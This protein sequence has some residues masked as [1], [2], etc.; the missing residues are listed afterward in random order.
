MEHHRRIDIAA[1]GPHYQSFQGRHA[2]GGIDRVAVPDRAR[3]GPRA[4]MEGHE[5]GSGLVQQPGD[6]LSQVPV[7]DPVEAVASHPEVPPPPGGDRIPVGV[8]RERGEE[9][10]V[11]DSHPHRSG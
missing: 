11:E 8:G 7:A 4:Q 6:P 9:S 5:V 2:H 3:G 1:A 10:S